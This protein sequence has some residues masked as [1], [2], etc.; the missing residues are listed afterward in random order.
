MTDQL[1][2]QLDH[3]VAFISKAAIAAQSACHI[4]STLSGPLENRTVDRTTV[5][6][7][8]EWLVEFETQAANGDRYNQKS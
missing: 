5:H 3:N 6:T 8:Q 4:S 1:Q 2:L 7:R